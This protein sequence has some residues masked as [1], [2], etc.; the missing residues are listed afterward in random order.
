MKYGES[1]FDIFYLVF[2]IASGIH[3]LRIR[4]DG[5]GRLMGKAARFVLCLL[6]RTAG[7]PM[8]AA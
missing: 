6:R 1:I 3:I 4:R 8:R 5:T 2:V 7:S